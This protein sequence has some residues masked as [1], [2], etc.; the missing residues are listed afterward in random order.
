[1]ADEPKTEAEKQANVEQI[2][3]VDAA[4]GGPRGNVHSETSEQ[5]TFDAPPPLPS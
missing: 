5:P 1:M 4:Q 3:T 2:E